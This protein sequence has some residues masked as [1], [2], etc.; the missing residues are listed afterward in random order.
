MILNLI[1]ADSSS[2]IISPLIKL[3]KPGVLA[4]VF[5]DGAF[6]QA[7]HLGDQD[8][9]GEAFQLGHRPEGIGV[10]IVTHHRLKDDYGNTCSENV[11][12]YFIILTF[13]FYISFFRFIYSIH[14]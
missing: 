3:L 4:L 8:G 13:S 6:H 12:N 9:P 10:G 1:Q 7:D 11:N 5:G 14:P 2:L